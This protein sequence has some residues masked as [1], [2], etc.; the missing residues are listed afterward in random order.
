ME[1]KRKRKRKRDKTETRD[2]KW[3]CK[4]NYTKESEKVNALGLV[5]KNMMKWLKESLLGFQ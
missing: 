3:V 1:L 5:S 2:M 4:N